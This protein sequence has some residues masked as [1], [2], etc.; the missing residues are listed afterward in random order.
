MEEGA[1]AKLLKWITEGFPT[2]TTQNI[3]D[4]TSINLLQR[5]S[6][7]LRSVKYPS[8]T[9]VLPALRA[10]RRKVELSFGVLRA[11]EEN[12]DI[13]PL[14]FDSMGIAVPTTSAEVRGVYVQVLSQLRSM[15]EVCEFTASSF[16]WC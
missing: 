14:P 5:L 15:L 8:T 10:S 3:M 2:P 4:A 1:Y 12:D 9:D 7:S 6:S 11:L 16:G 13:D